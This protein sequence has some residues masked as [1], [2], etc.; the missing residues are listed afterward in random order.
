RDV[1]IEGLAGATV[2]E[3]RLAGLLQARALEEFDDL[4]L[5]RA[6]EDGAGQVDAVPEPLREL[7]D[8]LVREVAEEPLEVLVAV[9]RAQLLAH[10][11]R[12]GRARELGELATEAARRPAEVRLEDL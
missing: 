1:L 3:H 10:C 5:P 11:G 8:R 2:E 12:A 7:E 4:R 6:V 9:D